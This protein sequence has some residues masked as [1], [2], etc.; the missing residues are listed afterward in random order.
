LGHRPD[1]VTAGIATN[2]RFVV[3]TI[4]EIEAVLATLSTV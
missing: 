4:G 1:D 3:W 2:A